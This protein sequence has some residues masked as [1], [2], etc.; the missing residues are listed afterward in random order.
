[1]PR[2]R[3]GV[4]ENTI[5][6]TALGKRI[7]DIRN[8]K[9]I[10]VQKVADC[11]GVQRSFINQL[12][13]GDKVPSFGTLIAI[14]NTLGVSADEVLYDYVKVHDTKTVECRIGRKLANASDEQIRRIEAHIQLELD[15]DRR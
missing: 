2:R 3:T 12:E 4:E 7:R 15:I 1:M 8:E 5:T 11:V 14:I 6:A 13:A 9:H 10:S